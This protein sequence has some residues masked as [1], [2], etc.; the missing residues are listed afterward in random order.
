MQLKEHCAGE[1]IATA[2]YIRE[3]TT[4]RLLGRPT[5][6]DVAMRRELDEV[7]GRLAAVERE[8]RRRARRERS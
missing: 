7:S 2:Q 3:S 6:T 5:P 4:A 1:G 8:L